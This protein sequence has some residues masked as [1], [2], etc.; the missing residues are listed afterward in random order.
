MRPIENVVEEIRLLPRKIFGFDDNSL[1]IN[2]NYT[3]QLFKKMKELNKKFI[4]MGNINVLGKDD[5]L[6]KLA[7]EAGCIAWFIGFES[8]SQSSL[9]SVGKKTNITKEYISSVKKIHDYKMMIIGSFVLGFDY[10]TPDIFDMTDKFVEKSEIDVVHYHQLMPYPG[11]PIFD[12]LDKQGR[13][14]TKDWN[15]YTHDYVVFKPKYMTPE[16]LLTNTRRLREKYY[17]MSHSIKRIVKSMNL[18]FPPFLE[19]TFENL[20]VKFLG[21]Q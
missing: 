15:K 14:L 20:A 12:R 13:I 8:V 10:D 7:S 17:K 2:P 9:I 11:T 6:L 21:Y 16:E 3:K 5:E 19:T 1:T 4:A 18:G